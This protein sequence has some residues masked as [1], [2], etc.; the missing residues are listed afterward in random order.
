MNEQKKKNTT[1]V[2]KLGLVLFDHNKIKFKLSVDRLVVQGNKKY[3]LMNCDFALRI[4]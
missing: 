4:I 1:F 2:A 3:L